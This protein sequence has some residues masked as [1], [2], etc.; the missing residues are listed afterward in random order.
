VAAALFAA[1]LPL[2][3]LADLISIGTLLAFG[4]V[5]IGII[6]LRAKRPDAPRAFRTPLVPLVPLLGAG[7]C[8]VLM[9]S[10]PLAAWVRLGGWLV[11]GFLI[12]YAYGRRHSKLAGKE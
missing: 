5:C 11:L 4:L 3:A 10:L 1:L 7:S 6:V 9:F 12:Y 8:V 2:D